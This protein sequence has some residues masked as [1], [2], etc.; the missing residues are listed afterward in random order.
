MSKLLIVDD[1]ADIREFAKHFF[2]KRGIEVLT[3]AGGREALDL[4]AKESPDLV[5]LDIRMEELTGVEVL[6]RL[7][8][9]NNDVKVVMVT[10]VTDDAIV[11]EAEE[12]GVLGYIHKP[13]VL[14]ELEKV[15]VGEMEE[16]EG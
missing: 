8:E 14:D 15:V 9:E 2:E 11:M 7:R 4:I 13:L 3:A 1:E 16:N 10:G 12:L 5:L 6:R